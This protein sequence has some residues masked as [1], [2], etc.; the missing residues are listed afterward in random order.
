MAEVPPETDEEP[1]NC[2]DPSSDRYSGWGQRSVAPERGLWGVGL[3]L[4]VAFVAFALG[5]W[6]A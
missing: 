5:R 6:T 1:M 4:A 2:W 3:I